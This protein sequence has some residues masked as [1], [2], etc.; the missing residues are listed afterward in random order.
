VQCSLDSSSKHSEGLS[1]FEA[2]R[3]E[4]EAIEREEVEAERPRP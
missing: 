1:Q 4:E 3:L 2:L